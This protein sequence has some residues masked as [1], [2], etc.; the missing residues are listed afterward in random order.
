MQAQSSAQTTE[1][2]AAAFSKGAA[3]NHAASHGVFSNGAAGAGA[4]AT[5]SVVPADQ[6]PATLTAG[7]RPSTNGYLP[8]AAPSR[9]QRSDEPP[10]STQMS[11]QEG[12]VKREPVAAAAGPA[13]AAASVEL[14]A[15][16]A[17]PA[18]LLNDS[19]ASAS[20]K[21]DL[22]RMS[23]QQSTGSVGDAGPPAGGGSPVVSGAP[24]AAGTVPTAAMDQPHTSPPSLETSAVGNGHTQGQPEQE[25]PPLPDELASDMQPLSDPRK[26][27]SEDTAP[28]AL[29]LSAED[30]A[31]IK[32]ILAQGSATLPG[33][34]AA[35]S[36]EQKAAMQHVAE[37]CSGAQ[38]GASVLLSP[39]ELAIVRHIVAASASRQPMSVQHAARMTAVHL[40][41]AAA[42][43][44][45]MQQ[46]G[47]PVDPRPTRM[48]SL[49][50]T[51]PQAKRAQAAVA[52]HAQAGSAHV[53]VRPAH[54]FSAT[55]PLLG[56]DAGGSLGVQTDAAP[57]VPANRTR[58][59]PLR[60]LH[61]RLPWSGTAVGSQAVVEG[62]APPY[63]DVGVPGLEPTAEANALRAKPPPRTTRIWRVPT[64]VRLPTASHGAW[65]APWSASKTAVGGLPGL[66]LPA[67]AAPEAPAS[68]VVAPVAGSTAL[69]HNSA[70]EQQR[71]LPLSPEP[72]ILDVSAPARNSGPGAGSGPDTESVPAVGTA[73]AAGSA[74]AAAE[75]C[76]DPI[77][78]T[79][80]QAWLR[81]LPAAV[82]KDL[83]TVKELVLPSKKLKLLADIDVYLF[84]SSKSANI[85]SSPQLARV[86]PSPCS[87]SATLVH[88][89]RFRCGT[90][91]PVQVL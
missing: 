23:I 61:R 76:A 59:L 49:A 14:A 36:H 89:G 71:D 34:D 25:A 40:P 58:S 26:S 53:D 5:A 77:R 70:S 55:R 60:G 43:P 33:A 50:G 15:L 44:A 8:P 10:G 21:R 80:L 7:G 18:E 54:I 6:D 68:A 17:R 46:A 74:K 24:A 62:N 9:S 72:A 22:R 48:Y 29:P 32:Q 27:G 65:S 63:E 79:K 88:V 16:P 39:D 45:S 3:A 12:V 57:G 82:R 38:T 69:P 2:A 66:S 52:S 20:L 56:P 31:A 51:L 84:K 85:S 28:T 35:L 67:G 13:S 47:M 86:D 37:Q 64:N 41:A 78:A 11:A 42:T 83:E 1:V 4:E 91:H 19:A 30:L 75:A 87:Y 81:D 73:V 90:H